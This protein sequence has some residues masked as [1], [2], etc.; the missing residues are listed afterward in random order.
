MLVLEWLNIQFLELYK[1]IRKE[2]NAILKFKTMSPHSPNQFLYN[3]C[4]LY[5]SNMFRLL[6]KRNYN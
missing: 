2:M 5:N 1:V 6:Q 3:E 4:I